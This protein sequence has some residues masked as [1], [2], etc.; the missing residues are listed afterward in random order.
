MADS[1]AVSSNP[2][3]RRNRLLGLLALV[4]VVGAILYAIYWVLVASHHVETDNAYVGADSAQVTPLIS[5]PAARVL[6][7]ETQIVKAG[8]PLVVL[9]DADAKIDVLEAQA[10]LGQAQRRVSGYYA[11]ET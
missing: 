1:A 6:V 5:A 2:N 3:A 4:V 9:D 11:N 7:S 8:Q 10:A